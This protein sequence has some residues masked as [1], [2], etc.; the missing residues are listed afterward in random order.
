MFNTGTIQPS[1]QIVNQV[2]NLPPAFY[3]QPANTLRTSSQYFPN[4][5]ESW[6]NEY[7][8]SLVKN[9]SIREGMSVQFRA[10][11]FNLCN[12]P[13]FPQDPDINSASPNFGKILRYNGQTNVPRQ[14]ELALRFSFLQRT[15]RQYGNQSPRVHRRPGRRHGGFAVGRCLGRVP[16]QRKIR[17]L[18]P[19]EHDR[20][21]P[22]R[23]QR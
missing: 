5:R 17:R 4:I 2:G 20:A 6:G 11:I 23:A 3:I 15:R 18:G 21:R 9:T 8:V 12:H 19:A 10:E 22:G 14:I 16:W 7:N 1:G 13:I